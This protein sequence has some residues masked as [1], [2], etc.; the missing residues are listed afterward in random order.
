M[1]EGDEPR[2]IA[3]LNS[4][5]RAAPND[6]APRLALAAAQ[7]FLRKFNDAEATLNALLKIWPGN[8]EA[9]M[10]LGRVQL[11]KGDKSRAVETYLGLAAAYPNSSGAYVLLAKVFHATNDPVG[12]IDAAKKAIELSPLSVRVRVLLVEYLAG[13]GKAEE[14]LASAKQYASVHPSPDADLLVASALAQSKR[15]R[16]AYDYLQARF[17]ASPN[18]LIA[19]E[20]SELALKF[21]D[22][23]RA[24]SW[25]QDWL[26]GHPSDYDVHRQYASLLLDTGNVPE[27]RKEFETLLKQQPEDPVVLNDLG[28]LLRDE[29]PAR[30]YALVSLAARIVPNSKDVMDTLAWLKYQRRELQGA[31]LLLR[32]AHQI[33][34][35][36]G[37]IAYHYAVVLDASGRRDEAK[38]VLQSVVTAKTAFAEFRT[39]P[40]TSVRPV[41]FRIARQFTL[42]DRRLRSVIPAR[43]RRPNPNNISV[44]GSGIPWNV[45]CRLPMPIVA[46]QSWKSRL[47]SCRL[48]ATGI[49]PL[50]VRSCGAVS[51]LPVFMAGEYW[52][53]PFVFGAYPSQF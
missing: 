1:H 5:I 24:L 32:R 7:T 30:A 13:A 35:A 19:R 45:I 28:W 20:L 15:D 34:P 25:L 29:D 16:E 18:N 3:L 2:S 27:A 47:V 22:Q 33:D 37:E 14:A 48:D 31:L 8:P 53:V 10:Q 46:G 43:P 44:A 21:G 26:H 11:L 42:G 17:A 40:K 52:Y 39:R 4:A 12:A 36:D 49:P 51:P 38:T 9:L 23:R 50:L 41:T 6:P